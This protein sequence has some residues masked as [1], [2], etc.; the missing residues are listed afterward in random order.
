MIDTGARR[1]GEQTG[2]ATRS[3]DIQ[4]DRKKIGIPTQGMSL[5]RHAL[6]VIRVCEALRTMYRR[7]KRESQIGLG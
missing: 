2:C 6:G 7:L 4:F 1:H 3:Y 5:L